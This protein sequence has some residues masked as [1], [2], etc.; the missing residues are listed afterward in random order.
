MNKKSITKKRKAREKP[1]KG[2]YNALIRWPIR[3]PG[4]KNPFGTEKKLPRNVLHDRMQRIEL[5][6]LEL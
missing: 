6:G 3:K 1:R 2:K 4:I 5:L